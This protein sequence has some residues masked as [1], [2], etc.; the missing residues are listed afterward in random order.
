MRTESV[1]VYHRCLEPSVTKSPR[2][3]RLGRPRVISDEVV[4]RI[5][6]QR[7]AGATLRAIVDGLNGDAVSTAMG[8]RQWYVSTVQSVL[9]A[10][11]SPDDKSV[12][13]RGSPQAE[14]PPT[15]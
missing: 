1:R 8:G 11:T 5:V 9:A 10:T 2:S 15:A 6:A 13:R 14:V 12:R 7:S 3:L 4:A